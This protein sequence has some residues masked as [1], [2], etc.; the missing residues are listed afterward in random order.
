MT[1]IIIVRDN[2]CFT[3]FE[4][5]INKPEKINGPKYDFSLRESSVHC[6][7]YLYTLTHARTHAH[8]Y[9]IPDYTYCFEE[10]KDYTPH[11]IVIAAV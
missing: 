3:R 11:I 6:T 8:H 1:I 4:F 2:L 9:G 5:K 10:K 7:Y